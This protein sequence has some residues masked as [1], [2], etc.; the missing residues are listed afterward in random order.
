MQEF[1]EINEFN[2]E[3]EAAD[4]SI[5]CYLKTIGRHKLLKAS[6]E[7]E[8]SRR[9]QLGDKSA[10]QELIN[11]NLRLVVNIAKKFVNCGLPFL[12]LIQEGNIGL[13]KAIKKFDASKGYRFSTYATW[14]IKQGIQRAIQNTSSTIRIPVHY[15]ELMRRIK[16]IIK[17]FDEDG[18]EPPTAE[19]LADIIGKPLKTI[20]EA[21]ENIT[22]KR[23]RTTS[24]NCL[25]SE[26]KA[27]L[28]ELI[29][30]DTP[31]TFSVATL[32][33]LKRHVK[34][35][36]SSLPSERFSQVLIQRYGL[37]GETPKTLEQIA[38]IFNISR[39]RIRQMEKQALRHLRRSPEIVNVFIPI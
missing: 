19:E 17:Q 10:E 32:S 36:L 11:S 35:L 2:T 28:L 6:E 1:D 22:E 38:S 16:K 4:D 29:P 30:S 31:D 39:E 26:D 20:K 18:L 15:I 34:S 21:M 27:E 8:I 12:D 33:I 13:I 7:I 24:F 5:K 3:I 9:I 14:W 25:I 37:N 23:E